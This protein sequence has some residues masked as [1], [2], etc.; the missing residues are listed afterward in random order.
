MVNKEKIE[1]HSNGEQT[2][3]RI[4]KIENE[5][6]LKNSESLLKL[7]GY[8]ISDWE[9]I[10]S[11]SSIWET[12]IKG[13]SLE[14]LYASKITVKPKTM[15]IDTMDV[16]NHFKDFD[17][18]YKP[19]IIGRNFSKDAKGKYLLEIIPTDLHL[20]KLSY[21]SE[22]NDSYDL[23]IAEKRFMS[24]IDD[25][26]SSASGYNLEKILFVW[27]NDYFNFDNPMQCT[28]GGT[29]QD[30]GEKYRHLYKA[31]VEILIKAI[32]KI[33]LTADVDVLCVPGNHDTY[34][35][36]HANE[37]LQAWYKC[38]SNVNIVSDNKLR[39]YYTYGKSII[40]FTHGSEEGNRIHNLMQHEMPL[41][42]AKATTKEFHMGHYHSEKV[43][44]LNGIIF[45]NLSSMSGTDEWHFNS[46]WVGSYLRSQS[47]IY[48]K[49]KGLCNI[50]YHNSK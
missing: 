29:F 6:V 42:Y 30:S 16:V 47:F 32:D 2:C 4:L 27:G 14:T 8:N 19:S 28:K 22:S 48:D 17:R 34:M 49:K 20:G 12:Q 18:T 37:L 33:K 41:E 36:F 3:E 10:N 46:G 9:L 40:G 43:K 15:L 13:G 26:I 1:I 7:H 45:R 39:K 25:T 11:K 21:V 23:K 5:E 35:C 31:G 44:E 50:I 38:D 24:M